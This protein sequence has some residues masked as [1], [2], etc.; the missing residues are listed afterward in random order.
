MIQR[1]A[2]LGD[3]IILYLKRLLIADYSL[4]CWSY[5]HLADSDLMQ[6][7]IIRCHDEYPQ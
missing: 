6:S 2:L 7:V 1:G 4:L 5:W 3:T